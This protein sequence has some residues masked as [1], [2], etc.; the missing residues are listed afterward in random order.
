MVK[1]KE[2]LTGKRFGKLLVLYQ[3]EDHISKNGEKCAM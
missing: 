3:A 1:V 2:D